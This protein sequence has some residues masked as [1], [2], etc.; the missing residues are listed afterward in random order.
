MFIYGVD[1]FE[2]CIFGCFRGNVATSSVSRGNGEESGKINK[3]RSGTK[4]R[5]SGAKARNGMKNN[6]KNKRTPRT[7]RIRKQAQLQ[8][9]E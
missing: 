9:Q 3:R 8:Q 1:A 6:N 5:V 2:A 4:T 7:K